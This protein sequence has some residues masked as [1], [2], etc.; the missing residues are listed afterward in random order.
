MAYLGTYIQQILKRKQDVTLPGFG[1]LVT[2][3]S[4]GKE[5][6]EGKI[7]PPGFHVRFD[8]K[9]PKEDD[10]LAKEY[11]EGEGIELEEARQQVLELIDA[12]KFKLDKGERFSLEALGEFSKDDNNRI[13]FT[14]SSDWTIDP[15][16][17]GLEPL[18]LLELEEETVEIN[19]PVKSEKDEKAPKPAP[20]KTSARKPLN[21]WK[22]IWMVVTGLIVVLFAILLIPTSNEG[23]EFGKGGIII[24][25]QDTGEREQQFD[26]P[27]G[28]ISQGQSSNNESVSV[29]DPQAMEDESKDKPL[30]EASRQQGTASEASYYVICGS[31]KNLLNATEMKDDLVQSGFPAEIIY[32]ENRLYRVSIKSYLSKEEALNDLPTIKSQSGISSLWIMSK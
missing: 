17:F 12:I 23:L 19:Q 4:S 28:D 2:A 24:R 14:K 26:K 5:S 20:Q 27:S 3:K 10:I 6:I 11:A 1:K 15:D 7:L 9:Q 16:A 32:T 25:N 13:Y 30:D 22:I 29:D 31:F 8:D 18:D 21:K